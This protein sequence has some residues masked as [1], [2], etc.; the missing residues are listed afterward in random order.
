MAN[1]FITV[2]GIDFSELSSRALDQALEMTCIREDA[3]VHVV[4]VEPDVG[5][6][7]AFASHASSSMTAERALRQ[8]QQRATERVDALGDRLDGRKLR[9]VVAHFRRGSPAENIA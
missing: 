9:R 7:A 4:Y 1:R 8:V 3:E 2:V 5:V 6:G